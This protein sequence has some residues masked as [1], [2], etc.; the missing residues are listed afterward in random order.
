MHCYKIMLDKSIDIR[1]SLFSGQSFLWNKD[2]SDHNLFTSTI[3][4]VQIFIRQISESDFDV[5]TTNK[6]ISGT[7]IPLFINHYF[8]LDIETEKVFPD[9]FPAAYP[10]LW[11]LL[12]G[13]FSLRILRQPP[14]ETM[15]SFMC[16][17]GIGMH[18][19]RKQVAMLSRSFGIRKTVTFCG[20]EITLY[21]FPKPD[22]LASADPV[23]LSLCTNNNRIRAENISHAAQAVAEGRIDF[24]ALRD[25][26]IPLSELRSMLGQNRGIGYKIADCIALFGLGRFDAFPI[27]THVRQYL[28]KWFNSRTALRSLSPA[29]YLV[30]DREARTFLNPHLAGY[31]GHMLFHCWR[32][33]V[34]KLRSF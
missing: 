13:Y 2:D 4:N 16:A 27:D 23:L 25:P 11:Q 12:S 1:G 8:T 19:I 30:L 29:N 10:D 6:E 20:K 15:I 14:F 32:N 5:Y 26:A 22:R 7:K 33:E 18:L 9:F 31:A 17:Q 24:S 28:G 21:S 3:D 34:K